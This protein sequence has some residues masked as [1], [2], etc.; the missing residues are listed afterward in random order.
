M[1]EEQAICVTNISNLIFQTDVYSLHGANSFSI[2][3]ALLA[4]WE[5]K[6]VVICVW[7]QWARQ[8]IIKLKII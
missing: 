1:N 4:P 3:Q 5:L 6:A 8:D 7:Q 2:T